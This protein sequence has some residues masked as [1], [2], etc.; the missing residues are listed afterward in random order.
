MYLY[1]CIYGLPAHTRSDPFTPIFLFSTLHT[2]V[3]LVH[4]PRRPTQKSAAGSRRTAAPRWLTES[5]SSTEALQT[6]RTRPT[7]R[8]RWLYMHPSVYLSI[9]IKI[10]TGHTHTPTE[11]N[12]P[13]TN[14]HTHDKNNTPNPQTNTSHKH[15]TTLEAGATTVRD[16]SHAR[17][18]GR[19]EVSV[20][21]RV[22]VRR[23]VYSYDPHPVRRICKRE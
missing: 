5:A 14:T 17:V 19:A 10:S 15:L 12:T 7:S 13:D 22:E 4:R 1:I 8:R 11:N 9:C 6:P 21:G 2:S 3:F 20:R 16:T 18:G 23:F